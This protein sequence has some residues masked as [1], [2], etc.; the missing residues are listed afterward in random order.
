MN[1]EERELDGVSEDLN[2]AILEGDMHMALYCAAVLHRYHS[3]DAGDILSEACHYA[4]DIK[5]SPH[6]TTSV[7]PVAPRLRVVN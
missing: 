4:G 6:I 7:T 3:Q 1:A 2:N 5:H